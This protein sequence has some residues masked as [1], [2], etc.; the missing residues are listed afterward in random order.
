M[1]HGDLVARSGTLELDGV[2][3]KAMLVFANVALFVVN[4]AYALAIARGRRAVDRHMA[5]Q[6]WHLGKLLP[7]T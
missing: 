2:G 5:S 1:S 4:A 7:P 6:A 3:A